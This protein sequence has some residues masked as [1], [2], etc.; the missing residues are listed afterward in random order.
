M[1]QAPALIRALTDRA[2]VGFQ[3]ERP[4][5]LQ[6]HN[7]RFYGDLLQRGSL[8]LGEGYVNG[9]WD[10]AAL[11]VLFTRLLSQPTCRDAAIGFQPMARLLGRAQQLAERWVNWQSRRR[12]FMVGQQHY[13]IDDR[14]YGA[15]LDSRR[16]Y[17]CGYWQDAVDLEAAQF[18]KLQ[19]I[20]QK[21]ELSPGQRLLDIG[22]GWGGL[23]IHAARHYGVEVVGITVSAQ[24]ARY[25]R[26][27]CR[28]LP[29]EV[30][31]CDYRSDL[32]KQQGVFDRV[33]SIGM[34]EHVG[35]RNDRTYFQGISDQLAPD[36]LALIQ[37]IGSHDT[38][39]ALD[40][41]IN[42]YIFPNGRLPSAQQ[43]CQGF[44][45]WFLLEDWENFGCDYDLTL[46]AW[47]RNFERSWPQLVDELGDRFFRLWKYYLLSCAGFF[48]SGQGQLWQLVLSKKGSIRSYRSIR[49]RLCDSADVGAA[50]AL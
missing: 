6:V 2:D 20:C 30:L 7:P 48:R 35:R 22:C 29:V 24:Q 5:D 4:W 46:L 39:M 42:T 9:D 25:C 8:A 19:R 3:G 33:V 12:A 50:L 36:G 44:E 45:S 32:L 11:D 31:L 47:W 27:R 43:L 28:D 34:L 10:C 18:H 38:N 23:A 21:L 17:S 13:D 49:P 26:E 14:V 16:L 40:P 15:M 41:W 37:T 1:S